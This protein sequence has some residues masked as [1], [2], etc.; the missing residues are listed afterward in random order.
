MIKE[1]ETSLLKRYS[2]DQVASLLAPLEEMQENYRLWNY[3]LDGLAVFRSGNTFEVAKLPVDFTELTVVADSFHTKPLR[4][5]LQSVDRFHLL[6]LSLHKIELYEGNRHGLKEI[7][8]EGDIPT[9]IKDALREELA[10]GHVTASYGAV[11]EGKTMSHGNG[12]KKEEVDV[13]AARFFRT[14]SKYIEDHYSKPFN[15]PLILAA[16]PEH[17]KLFMEVNKNPRLLEEGIKIDPFSSNPFDL[18]RGLVFFL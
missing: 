17:H 10:D 8:M 16:L 3:T 2:Q 14:V 11:R 1:A 13:D 7:D 12:S 6:G 5:Y 15:M 18:S 4:K 9:T